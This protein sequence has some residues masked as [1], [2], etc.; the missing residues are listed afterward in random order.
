MPRPRV[1]HVAKKLPEHQEY[2]L[3][4]QVKKNLAIVGFILSIIQIL[5]L[6]SMSQLDSKLHSFFT[7]SNLINPLTLIYVPAFIGYYAT[8]ALTRAIYGST[9]IS[10]KLKDKTDISQGFEFSKNLNY[11]LNHLLGLKLENYKDISLDD[12]IDQSTKCIN[13][14]CFDRKHTRDLL[15]DTKR[16]EKLMSNKINLECEL[17]YNSREY[18]LAQKRILQDRIANIKLD[19]KDTTNS[20]VINIIADNIKDYVQSNKEY[21]KDCCVENVED[22]VALSNKV[23]NRIFR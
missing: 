15:F 21:F 1:K 20:P 22:Q 6:G 3:A 23:R 17:Y 12:L 13:D 19:I 9:S 14:T 4:S 18:T 16:Y 10:T 8:Y 5:Y 11:S 2:T 7:S